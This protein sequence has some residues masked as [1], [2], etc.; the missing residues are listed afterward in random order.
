MDATQSKQ[1][2]DELTETV[3]QTLAPEFRDE[4]LRQYQQEAAQGG[5]KWLPRNSQTN[6]DM[7][8]GIENVTDDEIRREQQEA[9]RDLTATVEEVE[10][11]LKEAE[12]ASLRPKTARET[13]MAITRG[14][15]HSAEAM[16]VGELVE[17]VEEPNFTDALRTRLSPSEALVAYEEADPQTLRGAIRIRLTEQIHGAGWAGKAVG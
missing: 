17:A 7:H 10:A 13:F 6:L 4:R 15:G 2:I 9:Q 12:Q 3:R 8:I 5:G 1:Q 11:Q 14:N 16:F